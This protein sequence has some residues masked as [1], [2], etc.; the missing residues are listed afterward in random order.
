MSEDLQR[1]PEGYVLLAMHCAVLLFD[2]RFTPVYLIMEWYL[3][4]GRGRQGKSLG[5]CSN[6]LRISKRWHTVLKGGRR[7]HL[8]ARIMNNQGNEGSSHA[9]AFHRFFLGLLRKLWDRSSGAASPPFLL[10][11]E[12]LAGEEGAVSES[13]AAVAYEGSIPA[14]LSSLRTCFST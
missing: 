13:S 3:H 7:D 4:A 10:F 5:D 9:P 14:S 8:M 11:E 12:D 1:C 2:L 6:H